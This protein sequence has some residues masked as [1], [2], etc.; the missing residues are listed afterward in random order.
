MTNLLPIR[1]DASV[2]TLFRYVLANSYDDNP[3]RAA[4]RNQTV[5][6]PSVFIPQRG[7]AWVAIWHEAYAHAAATS[8][9]KDELRKSTWIVRQRPGR[10]CPTA[11]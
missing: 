4:A 9:A 11:A 3:R 2:A 6:Y 10:C 1:E 7:K 5:P 8:P